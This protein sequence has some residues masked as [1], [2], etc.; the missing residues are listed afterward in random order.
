[1]QRTCEKFLLV[2]FCANLAVVASSSADDSPHVT[3][4]GS[5]DQRGS[6]HNRRTVLHIVD[7]TTSTADDDSKSAITYQPINHASTGAPKEDDG[8][9]R[10]LEITLDGFR[11]DDSLLLMS[12]PSRDSCRENSSSHPAWKIDTS[13]SGEKFRLKINHAASLAGKTLF[14]CVRSSESGELR[15]LGDRSRF[16][17]GG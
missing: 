4:K 3:D 11:F 2:V 15:H 8:D 6:F 17:V 14:L 16:R 1:M 13:V 9:F 7:I 5:I 10:L 12:T